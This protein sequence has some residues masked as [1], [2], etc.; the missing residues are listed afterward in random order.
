MNRNATLSVT[1]TLTSHQKGFIGAMAGFFNLE[2]K[3]MGAVL[4][5]VPVG[6]KRA[7]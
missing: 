5:P 4:P 3:L 7:W 1:L 2:E 6:Q